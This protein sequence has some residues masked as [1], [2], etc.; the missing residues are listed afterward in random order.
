MVDH[1]Y[2][3]TTAKSWQTFTEE[4]PVLAQKGMELLFRQLIGLAFLAT[5]RKDGAP[6][7][8][9]ISLVLYHGHLYVMIPRSSP[10][11]AD[12]IRDNRYALQ[13]FPPPSGMGEEFYISGRAE[14]IMDVK[15]RQ[16]IIQEVNM[17]VRDDEILFELLLERVMYSTLEKEGT[18]EERPFH[19]KWQ[20]AHTIKK[21]D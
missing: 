4:A 7:L 8:H 19:Q 11:C 13:A 10:K 15:L 2:E 3:Q 18:G 12:L 9:P 20:A 21:S 6:R 5:L 17:M 1:W 16:A 14:S